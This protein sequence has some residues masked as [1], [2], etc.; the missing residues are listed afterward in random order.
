MIVLLVSCLV[1][2]RLSRITV[3]SWKYLLQKLGQ[4]LTAKIGFLTAKVGAGAESPR[5]DSNRFLICQ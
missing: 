4:R 5:E 1:E 3:S 2:P